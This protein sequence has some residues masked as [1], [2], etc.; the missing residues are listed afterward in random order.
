MDHFQPRKDAEDLLDYILKY[1]TTLFQNQI[2]ASGEPGKAV[3]QF[4]EQFIETYSAYLS[5]RAR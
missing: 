5:G 1:Q 3:A 2:G 4:C